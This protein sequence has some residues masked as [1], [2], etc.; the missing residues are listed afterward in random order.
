MQKCTTTLNTFWILKISIKILPERINL[1]QNGLYF[2]PYFNM[3]GGMIYH[4]KK[5]AMPNNRYS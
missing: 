3:Y 1:F 5:N 2:Y 4:S